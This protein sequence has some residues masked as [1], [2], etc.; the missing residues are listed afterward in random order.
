MEMRDNYPREY[1]QL[2]NLVVAALLYGMRDQRLPD[3]TPEQ[4]HFWLSSL[5]LEAV[6]EAYQAVQGEQLKELLAPF[7]AS[8]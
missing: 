6:Q 5:T 8:D 4:V 2:L 1:K 7:L 3:L